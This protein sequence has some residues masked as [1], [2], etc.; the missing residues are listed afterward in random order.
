MQSLSINPGMAMR[1]KLIW[2]FFWTNRKAIRTEGC[3]PFQIQKIVSGDATFSPEHGDVLNLTDELLFQIESDLNARKPVAFT[4]KLGLETF[5]LAF[6]NDVLSVAAYRNRELEIEIVE[7]LQEEMVRGKPN[8]CS[9]F[10][11]RLGIDLQT[12]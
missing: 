2:C 4:I 12:Q 9:S 10:I 7:S 6:Q 8:F 5:D 11:K 3:A 1:W